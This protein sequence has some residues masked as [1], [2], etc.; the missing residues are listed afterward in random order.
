MGKLINLTGVNL[1]K[2][3]VLERDTNISST[4]PYWICRC[5]CGNTVSIMGDSIRRGR[6]TSCGCNKHNKSNTRL[7]NIWLKMKSRCYNHN[8]SKYKYYGAKGITICEDWRD[9]NNFYS[10]SINNDYN[11]TLTL[12]RI[13]VYSNYEPSNC[14]WI[15]HKEQQRNKTNTIYVK[16]NNKTISISELAEITGL[17]RKTLTKRYYAGDTGVDLVR[18]TN[19]KNTLNLTAL[20]DNYCINV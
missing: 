8:D 4:K 3:T 12:D 14:R 5:E 7:Y 20:H 16:Y 15:T 2:L 1:G 19:R 11:D 18:F 17:N 10:W 13:N 9:F 6:T